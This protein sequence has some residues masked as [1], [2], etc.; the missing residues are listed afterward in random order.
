MMEE[1]SRVLAK[2]ERYVRECGVLVTEQR[3]RVSQC[4]INGW[5]DSGPRRVLAEMEMNYN[6]IVMERDRL[7]AQRAYIDELQRGR[8]PIGLR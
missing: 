4:L 3:N 2:A 5:D 8:R 6:L 1:L 7:K